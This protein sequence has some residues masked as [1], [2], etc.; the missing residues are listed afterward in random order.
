VDGHREFFPR[1]RFLHPDGF[2]TDLGPRPGSEIRNEDTEVGHR[3]LAA[4]ERLSYEPSAIVHRSVSENSVFQQDQD[5]DSGWPDSS[6][7][8][9]SLGGA[10]A[11]LTEL[12][13]V[14]RA[15]LTS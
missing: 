12:P 9:G 13:S 1:K 3:S 7:A 11:M 10:A 6:N 15:E 14:R 5:V 4:G 8:I 2:R